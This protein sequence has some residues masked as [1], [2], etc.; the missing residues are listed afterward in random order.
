MRKVTAVSPLNADRTNCQGEVARIDKRDVSNAAGHAYK[1]RAKTEAAGR[2]VYGHRSSGINEREDTGD[3]AFPHDYVLLAISS[4]VGGEKEGRTKLRD[5]V[6]GV[7]DN[8]D[9]GAKRAVAV[10]Q[11][12]SAA[13]AINPGQR[14]KRVRASHRH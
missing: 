1:L 4:H 13:R 3:G 6:A 8:G 7:V 11:I 2:Q 9:V 12:E 10:P 5:V 14:P